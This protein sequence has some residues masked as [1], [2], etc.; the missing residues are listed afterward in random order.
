RTLQGFGS[1]LTEMGSVFDVSPLEEQ[2]SNADRRVAD[3]QHN[4]LGPL[5]QL[6][7]AAA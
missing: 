6:E 1:V 7:H 5:S 3:M 2:L 4:L